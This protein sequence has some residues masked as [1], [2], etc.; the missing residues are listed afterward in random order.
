MRK[1]LKRTFTENKMTTAC[2]EPELFDRACRLVSGTSSTRDSIGILREKSVHAVLKSYYVPDEGCHEIIMHNLDDSIPRRF[3]ADAL[4][5]GEIFEIQSK[6]FYTMKDK[7]SAFLAGYDVTIVYPIAVN[8]MIHFINKTTGEVQKITASPLHGCLY[9]LVP[10]LYGISS[11]LGNERLHIICCFINM[12]EY[13]LLNTSKKKQAV[14]SDK[15]PTELLGEFR[16]DKPADYINLLPGVTD[17]RQDCNILPKAFTTT[18]VAKLSGVHISYA[19]MLL[20]LLYNIGLVERTGKQGNS[21]VYAI[22]L[23]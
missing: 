22:T 17:C 20:K 9:D 7:L 8:K 13:R 15:M 5:Q 23:P 14:K 4:F 16:I 11:F 3:V 19:Q 18:D 2:L 6:S 12:E 1:S 21:Y 10:E